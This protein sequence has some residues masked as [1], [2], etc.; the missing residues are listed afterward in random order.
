MKSFFSRLSNYL[1][2]LLILSSVLNI[3]GYFTLSETL[4]RT[5]LILVDTN[6][7]ILLIGWFIVRAI[8]NI[9]KGEKC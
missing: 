4:T 2:I 6:M 1:L 9:N 8:E 3:G 5:E 7:N